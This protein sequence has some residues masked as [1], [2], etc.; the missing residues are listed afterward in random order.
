MIGLEA[1]RAPRNLKPLL[2][3][4]LEPLDVKQVK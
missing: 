4:K 1:L 3:S 2:L